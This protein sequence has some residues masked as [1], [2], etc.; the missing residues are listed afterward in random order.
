MACS[1]K[2]PTV[3]P[4]AAMSWASASARSVFARNA[5]TVV[6]ILPSPTR[7]SRIAAPLAHSRHARRPCSRRLKCRRRRRGFHG[8]EKG[9]RKGPSARARAARTRGM[10]GEGFEESKEF[11]EF[12]RVGNRGRQI[13]YTLQFGNGPCP[14]RTL[15]PVRSGGLWAAW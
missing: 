10:Y 12:E 14:A 8:D 7:T 13:L 11:K 4:S 1:G 3:T 2:T 9:Y 6:S 15:W 5:P